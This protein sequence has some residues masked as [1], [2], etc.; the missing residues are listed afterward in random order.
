MCICHNTCIPFRQNDMIIKKLPGSHNYSIQ[1]ENEKSK[2]GT[3][4]YKKLTVDF[5]YF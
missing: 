1:N 5:L 3:K 2:K 4:K